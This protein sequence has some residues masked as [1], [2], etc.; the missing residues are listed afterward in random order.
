M[1]VLIPNIFVDQST[2]VTSRSILGRNHILVIVENGSR[3]KEIQ[4][5]TCDMQRGFP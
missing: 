3:Y 4:V 1:L 5:R 2:F